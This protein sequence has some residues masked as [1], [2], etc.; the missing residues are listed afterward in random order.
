ME[1]RAKDTSTSLL[2]NGHSNLPIMGFISDL[3]V[4]HESNLGGH[5]SHL[6]CYEFHL[7]GHEF[8]KVWFWLKIGLDQSEKV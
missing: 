4:S 6:R 3:I 1:I 7:G 8:L 2:I 5:G